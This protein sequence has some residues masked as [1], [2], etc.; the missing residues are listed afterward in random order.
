MLLKP[1]PAF[2]LL[3][4]RCL[5]PV[6]HVTFIHQYLSFTAAS[7]RY[8]ANPHIEA[9]YSQTVFIT[10]SIH[11]HVQKCTGRAR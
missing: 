6:Q 10:M 4:E 5:L 9:K 2:H 7:A 8:F 11:L 1:A 3:F